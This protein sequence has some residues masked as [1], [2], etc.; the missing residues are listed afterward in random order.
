M[1]KLKLASKGSIMSLLKV[2]LVIIVVLTSCKI[3]KLENTSAIN[4]PYPT[5]LNNA[6]IYQI[7]PQSY[8]DS[9]G[10]GIGDLK[11]VLQKANYID[12]L[13][14][15]TVWFNPFYTSTFFDA[16]YDVVDYYNIDPRY[17]TMDDFKALVKEFKKRDIKIVLD[18]VAG[19]TS[20]EHPWFKE[21]AK[22]ENNE[23]SDRYIW[24]ENRELLP[25]HFVEND[26]FGRNGN[27]LP[28]FF[29]SQPALNYGYATLDSEKKWQQGINTP[30]PKATREEL[31]KIMKYWL[32]LGAD[33]F[34][35][36]MAASLI[37]NDLGHVETKKLWKN[38]AAWLK[39]Q[40]PEAVLVAEWSNPSV[41][42]D[43]GFDLDFLIHFGK[44]EYGSLFFNESGTFKR[45]NCYFDAAGKGNILPFIENYQTHQKNMNGRGRVSVPTSNHDFQRPNCGTRSGKQ[46][47]VSMTFFL[48]W[49]SVPVIYYGDEIGM[50]FIEN[51]PDKEGSLL[52]GIYDD[53]NR[54]GSRTPMQWNKS[55]NAGFSDTKNED[56]LYLPIDPNQNRPTVIDQQK[57]EESLLNFTK[58]LVKLRKQSKALSASGKLNIL[59]AE[60]NKYPLVYERSFG[61]ESYIICLNPSNKKVNAEFTLSG[62]DNIEL[63]FVDGAKIERNTDSVHLTMEGISYAIYKN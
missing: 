27:F 50:R 25:K 59:Y 55:L 38:Y 45:E 19:H 44:S 15:N 3:N 62:Y 46:L 28:N 49:S 10:D 17:G 48:T 24:T 37:K 6:I 26:T 16:G 11:G 31:K 35:V 61:E 60:K 58:N 14:I 57:K 30:G 47:K 12:S 39:K 42:I 43:A 29:P 9:D 40:N 32:D 33:G 63:V 8:K 22:T 56:K 18:L 52:T 2:S 36:D 34:R 4:L 41:A 23:L 53:C 51:L 54:A 20:I 13:G 5:W 1:N 7:Y 21:S